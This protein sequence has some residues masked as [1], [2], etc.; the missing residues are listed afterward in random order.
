MTPSTTFQ[1]PL[2]PAGTFHPVQVLS[3]EKRREA[4][5]LHGGGRDGGVS[6]V[7]T[8]TMVGFALIARLG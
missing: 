7:M 3:I 1:W 4:A 6:R 2:S 8:A 5:L